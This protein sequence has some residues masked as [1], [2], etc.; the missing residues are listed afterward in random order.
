MIFV[1]KKPTRMKRVFDE[2]TRMGNGK[3]CREERLRR[4]DL[5]PERRDDISMAAMIHNAQIVD[6][7][8]EDR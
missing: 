7:K 5:N 8:D 3:I 1:M 4:I 6:E 2:M